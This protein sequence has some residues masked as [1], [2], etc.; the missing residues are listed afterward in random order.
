LLSTAGGDSAARGE[1]RDDLVATWWTS[2]GGAA[3]LIKSD[4]CGIGAGE[5]GNVLLK[6]PSTAEVA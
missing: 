5:I 1:L 3:D 6:H 4:G 2:G